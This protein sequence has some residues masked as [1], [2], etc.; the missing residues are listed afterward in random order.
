MKIYLVEH[1]LAFDSNLLVV[2]PCATFEIA[3]TKA[4]A[5]VKIGNYH[6][7]V[8]LPEDTDIRLIPRQEPEVVG[9]LMAK[10]AIID[11]PDDNR[12][13]ITITEYNVL[14]D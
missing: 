9:R 11:Q 6:R 4:L 7:R 10:W 8:S 1:N 2:P 12:D 14:E 13:T 3:M 5:F